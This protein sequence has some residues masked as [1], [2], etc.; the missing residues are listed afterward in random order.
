M[1]KG[2]IALLITA[3]FASP[4]LAVDNRPITGNSICKE[5]YRE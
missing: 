3:A 1:K 5:G 4:S 2:I